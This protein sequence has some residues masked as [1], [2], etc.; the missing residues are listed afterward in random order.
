[1]DKDITYDQPFDSCLRCGR[2]L[3]L[4]SDSC[5]LIKIEAM[6]DP[7]PPIIS[8]EDMRQQIEG[9]IAQMKDLSPQEAMD[10]VYRRLSFYLCAACYRQ[11]IE[12]PTG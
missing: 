10:Q 12:N 8:T 1:M 4:G 3:G 9:L 2:E 7:S 11:W 6:A 5:Y